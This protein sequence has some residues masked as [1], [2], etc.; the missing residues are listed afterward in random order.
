[1][2]PHLAAR[3]RRVLAWGAAIVALLLLLSRGLPAYRTWLREERVAAAELRASVARIEQAMRAARATRDTLAA[4][5]ARLAAADS[6]LLAAESPAAA[7]ATLAAR[8]ADSAAAAGARL[9]AVQLRADSAAARPRYVQ[10]AVRA[11]L[12]AD[13]RALTRLLVAIEGDAARLRIAELT[14]SQPEVAAPA[15]RPEALRVELVVE[16]LA[17]VTGRDTTDQKV[18]GQEARP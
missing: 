11:D 18:A 6:A 14:V 15:T 9:G 1:M 12:V 16:A 13:I 3:D 7:G 2:R 8:V 5:R 17:R 4:R 10:V